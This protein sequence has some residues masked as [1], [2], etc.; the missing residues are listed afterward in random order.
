MVD[1]RWSNFAAFGAPYRLC[2]DFYINQSIIKVHH[3]KALDVQVQCV[4]LTLVWLARPSHLNA[5]GVKGKD[6]LAAVTISSQLHISNSHLVRVNIYGP[7]TTQE[8]CSVDRY[9]T[10]A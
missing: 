5:Q 3:T 4:A 9:S 1:H 7:A 6:G 2:S 8:Y 10:P